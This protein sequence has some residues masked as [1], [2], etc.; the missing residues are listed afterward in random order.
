MNTKTKW[1]DVLPISTT[2]SSATIMVLQCLFFT[3][4]LSKEPDQWKWTWVR[5]CRIWQIFCFIM[6]SIYFFKN[7]TPMF[8]CA[9]RVSSLN[10]QNSSE[11][12]NYWRNFHKE[13]ISFLHNFRITATTGLSPAVTMLERPLQ[14]RLDLIRDA[15]SQTTKKEKACSC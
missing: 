8:E 6:M 14:T 1:L 7:R 3:F 12:K 13:T 15:A 9:S 2:A 4:S 10:S 11:K 5:Q